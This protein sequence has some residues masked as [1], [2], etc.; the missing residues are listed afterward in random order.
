MWEDSDSDFLLIALTEDEQEKLWQ[1]CD[2]CVK[3]RKPFNLIDLVLFHVPFREVEDLDVIAAPTL[4]NAQAIIV[5][6]RYCLNS[7][8]NARNALNLL[9][10]RKT[11]MEDLYCSLRPYALPVLWV[12][13]TALVNFKPQENA[14]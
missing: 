7:N 11:L 14:Q 6:L 3:A 9:N 8:H 5:I 2:A 13:L 10:S 4:N 12:S 1:T